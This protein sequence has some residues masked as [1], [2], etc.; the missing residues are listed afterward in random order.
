MRSM[1]FQYAVLTMDLMAG[2]SSALALVRKR[3]F[4]NGG[5]SMGRIGHCPHPGGRLMSV[6][7][8]VTGHRSNNIAAE[9]LLS[10]RWMHHTMYIF[11][12]TATDRLRQQMQQL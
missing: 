1:Y 4:R 11:E 2:T 9:A 3:P 7:E 6:R 10:R 5:R 12:T 8:C